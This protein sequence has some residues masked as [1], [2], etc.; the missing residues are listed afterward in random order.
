MLKFQLQEI[1]NFTSFKEDDGDSGD[2]EDGE[3]E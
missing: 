2:M 3:E 1:I